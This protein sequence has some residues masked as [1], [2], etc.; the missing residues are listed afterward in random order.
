MFLFYFPGVIN[1]HFVVHHGQSVL[2]SG[3]STSR[4]ED[5][6]SFESFL[7][8]WMFPMR[9]MDIKQTSFVQLWFHEFHA[10]PHHPL[11]LRN[12]TRN[13]FHS[14]PL[15]TAEIITVS[16]VSIPGHLLLLADG[17]RLTEV[18]IPNHVLRTAAIQ[19]ECHFNLEGD[20]LYSV[21]WYK[22]SYEFYR[23]V[24]RD[25]PPITTFNRTGVNVDV[26]QSLPMSIPEWKR[27]R[28]EI[29]NSL[30]HSMYLIGEILRSTERP[31]NWLTESH[32][33]TIL[34]HQPLLRMSG[35]LSSPFQAVFADLSAARLDFRCRRSIV[36]STWVGTCKA[37]ED[38][39]YVK[40]R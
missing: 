34:R 28:N 24:P 8:K 13:P 11:H 5:E 2:V 38:D 29:W 40:E 36:Q 1:L 35:R 22:D 20:R 17:L 10:S 9:P 18:R 7:C 12:N 21:K 25:T 30:S 6:Y 37:K 14:A 15:A 33:P 4:S 31:L 23:Y 3:E 16:I 39:T 19:L 32:V 26:S 27:R